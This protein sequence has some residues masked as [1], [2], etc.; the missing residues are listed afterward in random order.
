MTLAHRLARPLAA[1]LAACTLAVIPARRAQAQARDITVP[2]LPQFGVE[3]GISLPIGHLAESVAPGFNLGALAQ[4]RAPGEALG[5]R[6]EVLY[7]HFPAKDSSHT[8]ASS[9]AAT[10]NVLYDVPGYQFRPYFIG[11]MGFYH[12]SHQGNHPGLN[13]GMGIDIPLTGLSA[14]L[15]ARMHW[16]LTTGANNIT[17]PISFGLRF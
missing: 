6:G 12:L 15:E 11:G 8:S 13:A 9:T 4:Y 17:I 5:V 16:A 10:L 2:I 7:Q 3:T 1:A 14:H